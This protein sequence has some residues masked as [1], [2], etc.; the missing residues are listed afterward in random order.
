MQ[1]VLYAM[2]V[3]IAVSVATEFA[4]PRALKDRLGTAICWGM[5]AITMAFLGL[6][7]IGLAYATFTLFIRPHLGT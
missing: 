2:L 4:L 3:M 5:M 6:S 1:F 7:T